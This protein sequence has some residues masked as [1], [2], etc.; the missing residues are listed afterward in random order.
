MVL[1]TKRRPDSKVGLSRP[2]SFITRSLPIRRPQKGRM[3]TGPLNHVV[4]KK[5]RER[6]QVT[7]GQGMVKR[8][9][10]GAGDCAA[11]WTLHGTVKPGSVEIPLPVLEIEAVPNPALNEGQR[12]V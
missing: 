11:Q 1:A 5:A 9:D 6:I 3:S 10:N 7:N 12:S 8:L 2:S 4:V